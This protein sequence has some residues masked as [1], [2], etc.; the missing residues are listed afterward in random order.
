MSVYKQAAETLVDGLRD[1]TYAKDGKL[2]GEYEL[3]KRLGVAR[4]TARKAIAELAR[5]GLVVRK[6]C[7][8]TLESLRPLTRTIRPTTT[9]RSRS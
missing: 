8:G 2:L 4:E 1:G 7:A 3:A 5:R 6:R 9:A